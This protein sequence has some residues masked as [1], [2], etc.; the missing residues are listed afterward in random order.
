MALLVSNSHSLLGTTQAD[1]G[2]PPSHPFSTLELLSLMVQPS[3]LEPVSF[4]S[5][6]ETP[7]SEP[8]RAG[9]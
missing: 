2:S 5:W 1:S 6:E 3:S 9:S 4:R 8:L 7:R